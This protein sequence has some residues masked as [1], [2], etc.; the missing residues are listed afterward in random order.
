MKRSIALRSFAVVACGIAAA[1]LAWSPASVSAVGRTRIVAT[2]VTH[3]EE[4]FSNP[5]CRPVLTDRARYLE[6]RAA[7]VDFATLIASRGAAL[8]VQSEWE[9]QLR[10]AD[11]DDGAA[12]ATT[13]GRNVLD[14]LNTLAPG[15]VEVDVHSHELRG[16]NYADVAALLE[17]LGVHPNGV[18]G[19][20]TWWPTSAA[21]WPRLQTPLDALRYRF[22]W[23]AAIL[24][25][26]AGGGHRMDSGAS[27]IWRPASAAAFHTHDP[28]QRLINVGNFPGTG[29]SD[30]DALRG[31]LD[32]LHAGLLEPG[33][34]YTATFILPQCDLDTD[35]SLVTE[36]EALISAVAGDV[37]A[38]DLVWAPLTGMVHMWE[39]EYDSV[40]TIYRP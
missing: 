11:W 34:L 22:T 37:D 24:W 1:W 10:V 6:N 39:D 26:A 30:I 40:P 16:Y 20:F 21:T 15:Q 33:H 19:G 9:Y 38:G 36:A 4:S 5:A 3:N 2:F 23:E 25:G 18:V 13:A 27:G 31:L 14:Y 17:G 28:G 32:E 8:N 35:P 12:R 7:L 29:A